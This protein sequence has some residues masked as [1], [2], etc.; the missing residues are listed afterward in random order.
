ML[1]VSVTTLFVTLSAFAV[2]V[3]GKLKASDCEL[4]TFTK[5]EAKDEILSELLDH[6]IA[7]TCYAPIVKKII[8]TLY[9]NTMGLSEHNYYV[10][11]VEVDKEH[12]NGGIGTWLMQ[13][14]YNIVQRRGGTH[15]N[16][17]IWLVAGP[18]EGMLQ[19]LECWYTNKCGFRKTASGMILEFGPGNPLPRLM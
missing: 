9:Y 10:S 17:Y 15:N 6:E 1:A 7:V 12:R 11:H 18:E 13:Q 2:G 14:F 3:S 8:G 19:K 16:G 4:K 5:A